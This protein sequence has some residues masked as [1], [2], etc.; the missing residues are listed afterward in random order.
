MKNLKIQVEDL[1]KSKYDQKMDL[2]HSE[3][4]KLKV[5]IKKTKSENIYYK[6]QY[7]NCMQHLDSMR[8]YQK[9]V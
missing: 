5:I 3:L 8:Q 7:S 6:D 9:E 4:H 2:I 1:L